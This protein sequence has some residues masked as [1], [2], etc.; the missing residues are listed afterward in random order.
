[1]KKDESIQLMYASVYFQTSKLW[2]ME[3]LLDALEITCYKH[4]MA[5]DQPWTMEKIIDTFEITSCKHHMG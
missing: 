1:M 3:K 2:R 5:S 4:N